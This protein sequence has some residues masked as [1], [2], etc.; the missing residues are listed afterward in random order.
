MR[1]SFFHHLETSS[2]QEREHI[3]DELKKLYN[4]WY[5]EENPG[6]H[7][8]C[9]PCPPQRDRVCPGLGGK[10]GN[11]IPSHGRPGLPSFRQP[12]LRRNPDTLDVV[13]GFFCS[14]TCRTSRPLQA[15][16]RPLLSRRFPPSG[17]AG[18]ASRGPPI[19]QEIACRLLVSSS[20]PR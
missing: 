14:P 20:P 4:R 15:C 12:L 2:A 7:D 16:L 1:K 19:G 17:Q 10:T 11:G 5:Q 18:E 3:A 9:I 8:R 13:S 6:H